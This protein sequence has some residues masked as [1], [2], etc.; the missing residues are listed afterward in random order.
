MRCPP[1]LR[2]PHQGSGEGGLTGRADGCARIGH[3]YGI[4]HDASVSESDEG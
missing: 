2:P 4:Q 3:T 1:D